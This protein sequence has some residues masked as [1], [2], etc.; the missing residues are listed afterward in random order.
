VHIKEI[1]KLSVVITAGLIRD[2]IPEDDNYGV[3][4]YC[5]H[6]LV[7]KE[8]KTRDVGYSVKAEAGVPHP[9]ASLCRVMV[10]MNGP[11]RL[12]PWNSSKSDVNFGQAVFQQIRPT[13]ITLV[14]HFSSLSRRLKDDWEHKV[15]RYESGQIEKVDAVEV[16]A[17]KRLILPPLPT[18]NKPRSEQYKSINKV[19]LESKPLTLGLIEAMAAVEIIERQRLETK[20]RIAL[21]LLDSNFEIALKEFIVHR[22]DLFP[23]SQYNDLAIRQLFSKRDQVIDAVSKKIQIPKTLISTANHYYG[24]RNKL[25]HERATVGVTDSDIVNYRSTIERLLHILFDLNF[26]G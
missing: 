9:D 1:G 18:V 16:I 26:S 22:H 20:N 13:L 7:A 4:F 10:R 2:R 17:S 19:Q 6:R 5:N 12:M 11:A 8:V 24:L 21:I 14:S 3:Y 15:F 23:Q 25:I